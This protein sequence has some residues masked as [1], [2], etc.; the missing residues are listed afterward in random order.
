MII[1]EEKF[2][3]K[4]I[5]EINELLENNN[6][7]WK[8]MNEDNND[9]MTSIKYSYKPNPKRNE[10]K[11]IA[12][13]YR[14]CCFGYSPRIIVYDYAYKNGATESTEMPS[15]EIYD[16]GIDNSPIFEILQ[17]IEEKINVDTQEKDGRLLDKLTWYLNNK[18]KRIDAR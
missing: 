9:F 11:T 5:D 2:K 3:Q 10:T 7:K 15:V 14:V 1:E 18:K 8:A 4:I 16:N 6:V 13:G 12:F 17:K